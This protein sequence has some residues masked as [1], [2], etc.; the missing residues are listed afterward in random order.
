M[1]QKYYIVDMDIKLLDVKD[2]VSNMIAGMTWTFAK[3]KE[4]RDCIEDLVKEVQRNAIEV[5]VQRCS[6]DAYCDMI[7]P[8]DDD[9]PELEESDYMVVKHSVLDCKQKLFE[10]NNLI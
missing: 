9:Y 10:E 3:G 7:H 5:A 4:L 2:A 8:G 6:E 1:K